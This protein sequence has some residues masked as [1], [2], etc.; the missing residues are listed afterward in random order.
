MAHTIF[1]ILRRGT[2]LSLSKCPKEGVIPL[3]FLFNRSIGS[4]GSSDTASASYRHG[5]VVLSIPLPS[6]AELCEFN[7]KPIT[8]SVKDF[9]QFIKDEDGGVERAAVYNNEG[10]RMSHSTPIEILMQNDF[11]LLINEKS[12]DVVP[13]K[14]KMLGDEHE[15]HVS[16]LRT[17]IGRLHTELHVQHYKEER[18]QQIKQSLEH[19]NSEIGTLESLKGTIDAKAANKTN[20]LVWGG[21]A[22]MALQFGF[23]A[24]LTW[25][26]Y[27][28]DIM[29]PVTYFVTYGTSV[30]MY[31]YFVLTREEYTFPYMRDRENLKKFHTE[32]DKAKFNLAKYNGIKEKISKLESE[33]KFLNSPPTK[34]PLKSEAAEV[35]N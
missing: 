19:L 1:S 13:P 20:L 8:H 26:E 32:A 27:S 12:Y 16:Q 15:H 11:K 6:R 23:L 7:L 10:I 2:K 17:L 29:E 21:L 30:L 14:D 31:A 34:L 25:W 3:Q 35:A 9:V 33:M 5:M 28:W 22:G 4:A 18:E 24:R